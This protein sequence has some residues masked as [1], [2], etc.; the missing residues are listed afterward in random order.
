LRDGKQ[1]AEEKQAGL[2]LAQCMRDNGVEDFPDP[3]ENGPLI[4]VEGARSI[5]GFQAAAEKAR[6]LLRGAGG[7][8][9]R[10]TWVLA[11]AAVLVAVIGAVVV[12]VYPTSATQ[13]T[14]AAQ[15]PPANTV[16]VEMGSSRPWS[17]WMG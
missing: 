3:T 17:P 7:P 11:G 16:K 15:E 4:N 13:A 12:T 1:S 2:K 14:P 10:K 6:C 8:V 9:K 5:P